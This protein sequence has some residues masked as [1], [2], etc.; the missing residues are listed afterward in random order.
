MKRK[1]MKGFRQLEKVVTIINGVLLGGIVILI[2]VQVVA[3]KA[4]ISLA[5][6]EEM[7][8]FSYVVYTFLAWPIACLYGTNLSITMILDKLPSKFRLYLLVVFQ[9]VMAGFSIVASYSAFLQIKNQ[10]GVLAPSNSW[11][12]MEWLYTVVFIC[13]LL[14]A[15]FS[16]FR[17]VFLLTGDMVYVTQ[18]ERDEELLGEEE[19]FLNEIKEE[20][21][22]A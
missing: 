2:V 5:G 21:G 3:R 22:R 17:G 14:C 12:H 8:Q 20:E 15:I 19:N 9:A 18:E 16:V 4:G 13:L 1:I 11:F 6:T 10:A 7:A